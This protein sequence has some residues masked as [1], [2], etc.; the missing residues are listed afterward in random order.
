MQD[1][2][3]ANHDFPTLSTNCE[4]PVVW[5]CVTKLGM[6]QNLTVQFVEYGMNFQC[7]QAG[8]S[9]GQWSNSAG[10]KV[11]GEMGF[12][13]NLAK[14]NHGHLA[15]CTP[16]YLSSIIM[17]ILQS[18]PMHYALRKIS[19]ILAMPNLEPTKNQCIRMHMHYWHMHYEYFNYTYSG[20]KNCPNICMFFT[21]VDNP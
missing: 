21:K 8:H 6:S 4:K 11:V 14:L 9:I 5:R 19:L 10:R 18:T 7:T 12:I 3:Q 13:Y 17:H 16:A 2:L 1:R 20:S 15:F